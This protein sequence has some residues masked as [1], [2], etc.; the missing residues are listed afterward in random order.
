MS[1]VAPEVTPINADLL[2]PRRV[3]LV[4]LQQPLEPLGLVA[5]PLPHGQAVD[6]D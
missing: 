4:V 2:Q 3:D 6:V 1:E 5:E